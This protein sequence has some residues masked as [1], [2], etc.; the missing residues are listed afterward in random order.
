MTVSAPVALAF[1]YRPATEPAPGAGGGGGAAR[2]PPH[3]A[4]AGRAVDLGAGS[5]GVRGHAH[6]LGR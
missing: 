6:T 1:E 5:R 4:R 3:V 2:A